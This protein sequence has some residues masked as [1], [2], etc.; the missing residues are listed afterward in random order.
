MIAPP[1][2]AKYSAVFQKSQRTQA[3]LVRFSCEFQVDIAES[4]FK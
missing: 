1:A 4:D 2:P 3:D